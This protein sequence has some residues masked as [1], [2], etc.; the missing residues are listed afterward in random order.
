MQTLR[1]L[2]VC[3]VV[4]PTISA[5]TI[6][7]IAEQPLA[8]TFHDTVQPV[9]QTYCADCHND[10]TRE[11]DL[12]L[13][14]DRDMASVIKNFRHWMVV[15][16][17]IEAGDMPPE[18]VD[19]QPTPEQRS[20]VVHWIEAVRDAEAQRTQG[21][22]GVVLARRLSS[23]EY[24]YTIRDLIGVDIQ[25]ANAF[26]IDPANEAGFDNSGESLTMSPALLKKY[27]A[28]AKSVS[29]HLALTPTGFEFAPH[30]VITNT[31]RD[32]FC[33]N[34]II[35]F[36]NRQ[37]TDYDDY[38]SLLWRYQNREALG[39]AEMTLAQAARQQGL[40]AR[41][42][43]TLWAM[44][45]GEPESVGAIAAIQAMWRAL[46]NEVTPEQQAEA[47]VQCENI[48]KFVTTLRESLV[49]EVPNLTSPGMNNGSQ[50]LVLWKNRQF[51]ANRRRYTGVALP[52]GDLG[53]LPDSDAAK[54]MSVVDDAELDQMHESLKRF[55][56]LFPDAFYIS[57]RA[58]VYL[59]PKKEKK[60][61]GRYLSAGFHSQMGYFRDDAPLYD[62]MLSD[63]ERREIDRLWTEL[64]FVTSA[65]MRQYSGFIWFDRTDSTFMRDREFDPYRAEDKDCTSAE[66]V[67][68]LSQV[69]LAK[70][71]RLGASD[72]TLTAIGR[73]FDEMSATFRRLESLR[74][75]SEAV[76]VESL[77]AFATRAFRRP[78]SVQQRED[79]RAF[80]QELRDVDGLSHEDAIRDS[81]VR[82][83]MSPHFCYRIDQASESRSETVGGDK[84]Q[85]SPEIQPLDDVALANRL[86]YF[87]WSSMPDPELIE[88]AT[89]GRL[90]EP[91]VLVGQ[92]RRMLRDERVHGLATEF[93]GNW[94]D[95]RRFEQHN[96]VDRSRFPQFT[97]ELRQA[98]YEEPI[99]FVLDIIARDASVL[100]C[101][102]ADHIL[103]NPVLAKHYGV[104]TDVI[105]DSTEAWTKLD[106]AS[107]WGRG[108]MLS[109]A[110]FLT[111]NSPGLRTSPVKRGNW[112]VKRML[113]EHV[114]A[115][116][117]TV[118]ELPEDESKL[119]DLTLREALARHRAD[120]SCAGC[121]ER[122]DSFGLAFEGY[123]PVG[124]L[125][126]SDLGGRSIDDT[127]VFPDKSKGSGLAGL[128]QYI[129]NQR[130]DDFVDNLCRKLLAY[131]LGR[132]LQLSDEATIGQMR[133]RLES[134]S[135]RFSSMVE[136]IVTS[137]A[138]LNKRIQL[139]LE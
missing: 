52:K 27:L 19:L 89:E 105:A 138:F 68:G 55:C 69:Y 20:A 58:R 115:P 26:P 32:K 37:R 71:R 5:N 95:F 126:D 131:G 9:L 137:P 3:S 1:L 87:L 61:K 21:D 123:G 106:D 88:L 133:S 116:P 127:A 93:T 17:R 2:I 136:V 117:A 81:V 98:M 25:P 128:L 30:P 75:R 124:E 29:E 125:R 18:D 54:A 40:S 28:A 65:P 7:A 114:P 62:L 122:I 94:L 6:S 111:Y 64:D 91:D 107:R 86:S 118:P 53:L 70:A 139:E 66:K 22:P 109:M 48:A 80:Y 76:H 96:G 119:G 4:V 13:G 129:R 44:L 39:H 45:K 23:S 51:V 113:G 14:A 134:Q 101:L 82:V 46:P 11:G 12:D 72:Q 132:S 59:D 47:E 74:V 79:I 33:V 120:S 36:Y 135:Y 35:D 130:Q 103:V 56:S 16:E 112:V 92:V 38:F 31:D 34:R 15:L 99:R 102:Y 121:H 108:G 73:Y 43:E 24:N 97:D 57:E 83:L 90:H 50:P 104:P 67:Q 85:R 8:V 110:V 84:S 100:E 63:S 78:L 60:L 41:Y 42:A 10:V 77:V 49:P